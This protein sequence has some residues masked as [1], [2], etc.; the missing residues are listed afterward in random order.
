MDSRKIERNG[1]IDQTELLFVY[2]NDEL[3]FNG[4]YKSRRI[5]VLTNLL[6]SLANFMYKLHIIINFICDL[7]IVLNA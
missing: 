5:L 3:C 7:Y 4:A 6:F 2:D 1:Y